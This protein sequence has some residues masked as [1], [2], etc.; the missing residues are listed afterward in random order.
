MR[1]I[2]VLEEIDY[3][4]VGVARYKGSDNWAFVCKSKSLQASCDLIC[5]ILAVSYSSVSC[6]NLELK[7]P[8]IVS[9]KL[10]E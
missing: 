4:D 9:F 2:L 1:Q 3:F 6:T 10:T 7:L 5:V 8:S